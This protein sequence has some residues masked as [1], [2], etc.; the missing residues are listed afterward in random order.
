MSNQAQTAERQPRICAAICSHNRRAYLRL[1]LESLLRQSSSPD[2]FEIIVVDNRSTDGTGDEVRAMTLR[3]PNLKYVFENQL[4]LSVARNTALRECKAPVI[5]YLDDDAVASPG[6]IDEIQ[7]VFQSLGPTLG[8]VGGPIDPIWEQPRPE[9]LPDEL[10]AYL[11]ILDRGDV[12]RA[13][14]PLWE[15]VYGANMSF[16]CD[17]LRRVGGFE[18]RLGRCGNRLL[19]GEDILAQRR[20]TC[21]GYSTHYVPSAAIRHH[22]A[23]ARLHLSWFAER[24]FW[25]GVSEAVML[26]LEGLSLG[27]HAF[28]VLRKL[29]KLVVSRLLPAGVNPRAPKGQRSALLL[30]R[31]QRLLGSL[32]GLVS[33]AS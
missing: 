14:N 24:A 20:L 18:P 8:C 7:R 1:A 25:Q 10:L 5:A 23:A 6:W 17:A 30:C 12:A 15:P 16:S 31:R 11:T 22:V 32:Y 4:G 33:I 27:T 28:L 21:L 13:L 19:S 3:H 26:R 9:W 29:A 2:N